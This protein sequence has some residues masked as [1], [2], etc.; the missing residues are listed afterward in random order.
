MV[1]AIFSR[2]TVRPSIASLAI[3]PSDAITAEVGGAPPLPQGYDLAA[4]TT[5][6]Q[7]PIHSWGA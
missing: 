1:I 3:C 4:A 2:R 6:P 5:R 7:V